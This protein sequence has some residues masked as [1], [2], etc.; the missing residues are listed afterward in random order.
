MK[1]ESHFE[2]MKLDFMVFKDNMKKIFHIVG[3][4]T[5]KPKPPPQNLSTDEQDKLLDSAEETAA[6]CLRF[7]SKKFSA[8]EKDQDEKERPTRN[9]PC[10][11]YGSAVLPLY[12]CQSV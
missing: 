2:M 12:P 7:L 1:D 6:I 11:P 5:R 10:G 9:I 4:I 3:K 8:T